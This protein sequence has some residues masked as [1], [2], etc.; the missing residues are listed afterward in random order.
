MIAGATLPGTVF[1]A[2][3]WWYA[4]SVLRPA[5]ALKPFGL[6]QAREI[7]RLP[8][9]SPGG[10]NG[11]FYCQQYLDPVLL[12]DRPDGYKSVEEFDHLSSAYDQVVE[13]FSRPIFEEVSKLLN[14]LATPRSR[15]LDCSCGPGSEALL[16]AGF[17][18]DG[19]VVGSD[20]AAEMVTTA[21]ARARQRG[22]KNVAFFQA[23]I[24]NLPEHFS[25]QFDFVYCAFAFHHYSEPVKSLQEIRRAL[26]VGGHAFIVDAGPWW[27]KA[28]ASPLAK[29]GDPG[30]IAFHTG[31]EFQSL[32]REAGFSSFYW[33]EIL[34]GIGLSVGTK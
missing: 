6:Y 4:F 21:A 23:D 27:M 34:P 17:V 11:R 24:T 31:E 14:S 25:E 13:P 10:G 16:L 18:P 3:L 32:F 2:N 5:Q 33:T 28:I 9:Q 15:I 26:R 20:L 30:W 1:A 7:G 12:G 29:W 8:V 19:E 22:V